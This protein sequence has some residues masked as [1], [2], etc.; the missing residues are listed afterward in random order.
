MRRMLEI[1][2]SCS[3]TD[4]KIRYGYTQEAAARYFDG[5]RKAGLPD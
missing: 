5:M 1:D 4:M 2:P 3:V